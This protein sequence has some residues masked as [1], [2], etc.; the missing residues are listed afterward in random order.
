MTIICDPTLLQTQ[1][2]L[3][4]IDR[5][6]A[7]DVAHRLCTSR[8]FID[9]R[10]E[11]RWSVAFFNRRQLGPPWD[12]S[13]TPIPLI[14]FRELGNDRVTARLARQ[15]LLAVADVWSGGF[16]GDTYSSASSPR[17]R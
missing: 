7:R 16:G 13:N 14:D 3:Q 8:A 11:T 12:P 2:G 10:D 15:G 9:G 1:R 6:V 17:D 5:S 4:R